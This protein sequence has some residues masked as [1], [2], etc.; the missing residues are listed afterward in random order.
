[1]QCSS[2]EKS[3]LLEETVKNMTQQN[4][5][6]QN[7]TFLLRN[8]LAGMQTSSITS[9]SAQE[10]ASDI[11]V[12]DF[13]KNFGDKAKAFESIHNPST[14]TAESSEEEK[15]EPE[16]ESEQVKIIKEWMQKDAH[17]RKEACK[18]Q[19]YID[20]LNQSFEMMG[21][22]SR[23]SGNKVCGQIAS[24]GF[25]GV[26]IYSAVIKGGVSGTLGAF[27]GVLNLVSLFTSSQDDALSEQLGIIREQLHTVLTDL[28]IVK[29]QQR[30]TLKILVE[31]INQI[32][33]KVE[34]SA[35]RTIDST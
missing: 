6:S 5:L 29:E 22:I 21:A 18:Q 34:T 30:Q 11:S 24:A 19:E 25:I 31:G 9:D 7:E 14:D 35:N 4:Q 28:S 10:A 17:A 27:T 26:N 16:H 1:M 8:I 23:L 33:E 20:T 32:L 2:E 12:N 15:K 13:L 3:N